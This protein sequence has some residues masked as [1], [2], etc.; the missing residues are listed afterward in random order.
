MRKFEFFSTT[1]SA[2]I[3]I[4]CPMSVMLGLG[5]AEFGCKVTSQVPNFETLGF[6]IAVALFCSL[7]FL[8]GYFIGSRTPN[9]AVE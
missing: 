9:D 2:M 1:G 6:H 3:A 7:L 8:A 4:F 5:F